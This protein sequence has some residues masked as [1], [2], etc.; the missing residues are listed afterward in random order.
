[1]T[2][3][4]R[5]NTLVEGVDS[6]LL[7]WQNIALAVSK[8]PDCMPRLLA[9]EHH[10]MVYRIRSTSPEG[11][12][13]AG[14]SWLRDTCL[15]IEEADARV[16]ALIHP[17]R[18]HGDLKSLPNNRLEILPTTVGEMLA[19]DKPQKDLLERLQS[20]TPYDLDKL[21]ADTPDG[22]WVWFF[23]L[24]HWHLRLHQGQLVFPTE[25]LVDRRFSRIGPMEGRH[26]HL[27]IT[28]N[29]G[30]AGLADLD[31]RIVLPC[32]YRWLGH[33]GFRT[34]LLEAQSPDD[35]PDESDLIDLSGE[36][37]NPPG[38]KL[39]AG[40]FDTADQAIV[41][42]EGT[43]ETGLKGLMSNDGRLLGE[44]RWRWIDALNE[45]RAAV[46]DDA[47][48]LWGYVD[49]LGELIIPCRC[50]EA[51][52]FN[53]GRAYFVPAQLPGEPQRVGLIDIQGSV[54]VAPCWKNMTHLPAT[55]SSSRTSTGATV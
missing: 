43:G 7:F 21:L 30:L 27:T 18:R 41:V 36:R 34:P 33:T 22:E 51:Y 35:R 11:G 45:D 46:H 9:A 8:E 16:A 28:N 13:R 37:I 3:E 25:W 44:M 12:W 15:C 23:H 48:G 2:T 55:T 24:E 47:S 17:H 49:S 6:T 4:H 40:S 10:R 32:R 31:G 38:I 54:V 19:D 39:M 5:K 1:M 42:R 52:T 29:K 53:D 14:E 20:F 26:G 50:W